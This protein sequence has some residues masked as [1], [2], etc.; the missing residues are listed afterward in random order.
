MQKN[1]CKKGFTLIELLAV[2]VILAII[3]LI[4][5]PQILK[6]LNKA[7]LKSAENSI[8]GIVKA[9]ENYYAKF[10][11]N[12]N[13][14]YPLEELEFVCGKSGCILETDLENKGYNLDG[15]EKLD[16]KGAK[17]SS[18][19]VKLANNG[20]TIE[21]INIVINEFIC[22][23]P[24][25][26]KAKCQTTEELKDILEIQNIT[27][28]STS[29]NINVILNVIGNVTKFEY[30]IDGKN[31]FEGKDNTYTFEN[32]NSNQ[33]YT[34]FVK[35]SNDK[36]TQS[37][38]KS[39]KTL[40]IEPATFEIENVDK[41]SQSKKVTIKYPDGDYLYSYKIISGTVEGKELNTEYETTNKTEE[42][43]FT[44]NGS[45][46][47]I[48][49]LGEETQPITQ[50]INFIDRT[51]PTVVSFTNSNTTNSITI[52]ASGI[53]NDSGM[54]RYQFSKNNGTTW[55]PSTPQ[56][57]N[58]YTFSN[59]TSGTYNIKVRVMNGTFEVD[60][61]NSLNTKES[62]TKTVTINTTTP[63][64]TTTTTTTTC[65]P[66]C[67]WY[68][69]NNV[70]CS[71]F[72]DAVCQNRYQFVYSNVMNSC[73]SAGGSNCSQYAD[74]QATVEY[75]ECLASQTEYYRYC[76]SQMPECE[77]RAQSAY[78]GVMGACSSAGGSN[79]SQ[80]AETERA[81][82]YNSCMTGK[83]SSTE[84][85]YYDGEYSC[86]SAPSSQYTNK[87]YVKSC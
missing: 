36:K 23:Y 63:T 57:N 29:E 40:F 34:V 49:K 20:K 52:T 62:D 71:G 45:L 85:V 25:E 59:L 73:S 46:V 53:D 86:T 33:E 26:E 10:L 18:G 87:E 42:L 27:L 16:Y 61:Q 65:T 70:T 78:S 35:V 30:S 72:T 22:N 47:A 58:K 7:R 77:S 51:A 28:T 2:I 31:Y 66:I 3:A 21:G 69:N 24:V 14:N 19:T 15:L 13:G 56:E 38:N 43:T 41:W 17:A 48:V 44:S 8:Y 9:T 54:S 55:E 74:N 12:N 11:M 32:L 67:K 39:I 80:S 37:A 4:A 68:Y 75:N 60:G 84:K 50:D 82:V 5:V 76:V 1:I 6:I 83:I 64:T 79:C 81:K